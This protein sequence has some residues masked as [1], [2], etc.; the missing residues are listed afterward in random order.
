MDIKI[1]GRHI[2]VTP[3]IRDYATEKVTKLPRYYDRV[4]HI[5]VVVS[6]AETHTFEVEV[7]VQAEHHT[8]F[9]AK[10]KGHDVY[11]CID[12]TIDKL[13]RQLTD[14]KEIVRA[15][16]GKTSMSG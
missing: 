12:G 13:E 9:V 8:P 10:V 11:A 6:K 1:S 15:R 7:I 5:E 3:A 2:E 14:H 4:T 16:K